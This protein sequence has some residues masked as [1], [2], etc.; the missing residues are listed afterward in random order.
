MALRDLIFDPVASLSHKRA[1]D[2]PERLA[3]SWVPPEHLRRLA[4]YKIRL[5]FIENVARFTLPDGISDEDRRAHREYGDAALLVQRVVAGVLG[6]TLEI[7]VPGA[8]ADLGDAPRLPPEPDK[9]GPNASDIDDAVYE[10]QRRVWADRARGTIEEWEQAW[11]DQPRL[12]EHQDWLRDWADDELLV[13]RIWEGEQQAV[14]LGDSVY[15][16]GWST[17]ARRP[18]VQVYDPGFYFPVLDDEAQ[19]TGFP[20]KVHLAWETDEDDDGTTDHVRRITY[21]LA[22]I[23]SDEEADEEG[24][25]TRLY[26]WSEEPSNLTCYLTDA[27]FPF[28]SLGERKVDDFEERR[29]IYAVGEDGRELNRLD[30]RID[31]LPVIHI[32]NTP[33]SQVH[34]GRSLLDRVAQLLDDVSDTDSD[35]QLASSLAGTP[36][37]AVSGVKVNA[38]QPLE[39][40]PGAV[41]GLGEDGRMSSIDLSSSVKV[42]NDLVDDLLERLS[43]NVQV[44][45]DLLGRGS[46]AREVTGVALKLRFSPF[47]QLV[48]V[49]RLPRTPK[50]ALML[51][52]A[53]RLAQAGFDPTNPDAGGLPPG[54]LP[55]AELVFGPF[56]PEDRAGTID[57][58][59]KLLNAKAI[60]RATALTMLA[61]VGVE[62][63]DV[64]EELDAIAH[65]DFQGAQQLLDAL[66][67]EEAVADYLGRELVN[68]NPQAPPVDLP[69]P[70]R[71]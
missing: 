41:F 25:V 46:I 44:P 45:S 66:G 55:P 9:P 38:E 10:A 22:P 37:V 18:K 52:F 36:M 2:H 8:D 39:I 29:A 51:K 62:I 34:F 12:V 67:D 35:L 26:P 54:L 28:D 23:V 6:E 30:L 24:N 16:L 58:V 42:L 63:D 68:P 21:E 57:E 53:G 69:E 3:R 13:Q 27:T 15:V 1:I 31:F 65:E 11:A 47:S 64:G 56:L 70:G 48:G 4:A 43:T 5:S 60:S 50:Y 61:S 20:R 71:P 33:A 14:G 7:V 32:P 40:K 59:V 17:E 49:L 19:R